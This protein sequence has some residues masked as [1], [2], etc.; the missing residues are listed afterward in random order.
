MSSPSSPPPQPP[1]TAPASKPAAS[2]RRDRGN[3]RFALVA[4]SVLIAVGLWLLLDAFGLPMPDLGTHWPTFLILGGL[5]SAVDWLWVSR[6]SSSAGQAV[7]GLGL[8]VLFYLVELDRLAWADADDWWPGLFFVGGLAFLAAWA[9]DGFRR[10][11]RLV[12]GCVFILLAGAGWGWDVLGMQALW[13]VVLI[14]FG[15]LFVWRTLRSG[16]G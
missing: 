8:G 16:G 1:P 6:R 15:V 13:A 10:Q 12:A 7:M 2:R 3:T 11:G 4:G 9:A 14:A 5:A